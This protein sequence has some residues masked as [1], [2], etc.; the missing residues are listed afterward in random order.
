[1]NN[2]HEA[3]A[4][5]HELARHF[6]TL[7]GGWTMDRR[8]LLGVLGASAAGLAAVSAGEAFAAQEKK[9]HKEGH[10]QMAHQTAEACTDCLNECNEAFHH[11]FTQLGAGKKEY[12]KALH[13]C[14]DCAEVCGSTAALCGR[15]S[16]LMGYCCEC[17]AKC[18][19]D[20]IAECEGVPR[21]G[22]GHGAVRRS[23]RK[24][25][26]S[27]TVCRGTSDEINKR[28]SR[29]IGCRSVSGSRFT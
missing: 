22:Q 27:L 14:V 7:I 25:A 9:V 23:E 1:M 28:N 10:G 3:K 26:D 16:P 4:P 6:F 13:L 17:C 8:E 29:R 15:M 12:A 2:V 19:D 18:C 20:C 5:R 21:H 11:C 24:A